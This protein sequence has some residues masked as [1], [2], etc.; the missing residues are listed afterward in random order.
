QASMAVR[1]I[2]PHEVFYPPLF[3]ALLAALGAGR[4]FALA[5]ALCALLLAASVPLIYRLGGCWL[6]DRAA[7]LAPALLFCLLPGVWLN[8]KG[9][10]SEPLFLI[11]LL[12]LLLEIAGRN[13]PG[14]VAMLFGAL[15]LT[16]AIGCAMALGYVGWA[17]LAGGG[18]IGG[19]VRNAAPG[20]LGLASYGAWLLLRPTASSDDYSTYGS[21][22]ISQVLHAPWALAGRIVEQSAA[23]GDAWSESLLIYWT[24]GP[25]ATHAA[26]LVIGAVAA[27]G[28]LLRFVRRMPDAWM[29]AGYC[30]AL[31]VWPF[32]GQMLRFLL[33][34]LPLLLLYGFDAARWLSRL[35]RD[36]ALPVALLAACIATLCAP[37][38]AFLKARADAGRSNDYAAITEWYGSADLRV[39]SGRAQ[40]HLDL[41]EL[42]GR[43]GQIT[44]ASDRIAWFAP[45]YVALLGDRLATSLPAATLSVDQY[46]R[47]LADSGATCALLTPYHPR[48]TVH[49]T[50]WR[51]GSVA[52]AGNEP[53]FVARR[54]DGSIYAA[55]WR[56]RDQKP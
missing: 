54:D 4:N 19:R 15:V 47:A 35:A 23:F 42:L 26:A 9:I 56:L 46:R 44:T 49:A 40:M 17:L 14:A 43:I 3:P 22:A 55:L 29:V 28:W 50:A 51:A 16:R 33:P 10:L 32:P 1:D 30:S 39:A 41:L 8:G 34:L 12:A 45:A 21:D 5:H 53:I 18:S 25:S 24:Q 31:L 2:F 11:V 48:D 6:Q 38:L 52:L 7:A 20:L 27:V 13:R 37:A 36:S